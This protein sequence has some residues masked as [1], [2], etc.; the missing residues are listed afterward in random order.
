MELTWTVGE[1]RAGRIAGVLSALLLLAVARPAVAQEVE[2]PVT[3][4]PRVGVGFPVGDLADTHDVG[5]AG[6]VG[7]AYKVHPHIAIRGDFDL[8]VLDEE[9]PEVGVV[10]APPLTMSHFYGGV[11]FDFAPPKEQSIPLT[12]RWSFGAGGTSMSASRDFPDDRDVD[13]SATYVNVNSGMKI[14]YPISPRL[15]LFVA[16]Q[17]F[18]TFAD[19]AEMAELVKRTDREPFGTVWSVPVTLGAQFSF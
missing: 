13:F 18:L 1:R 3:V 8:L 2:L 16:G 10:L 7:V 15:N 14:G 5:F 6:G 11:E 17:A 9:S 4:D 19:R 12:L